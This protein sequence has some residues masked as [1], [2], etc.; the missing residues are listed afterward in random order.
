[1]LYLTLLFSVFAVGAGWWGFSPHV[2]TETAKLLYGFFVM[3]GGLCF[4]GTVTH[5]RP[6]PPRDRDVTS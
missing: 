3:M 6:A 2:S 1:M 4:F 5:K